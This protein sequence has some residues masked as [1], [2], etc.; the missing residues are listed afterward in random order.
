MTVDPRLLYL[1]LLTRLAVKDDSIET[2][3][4]MI[5]LWDSMTDEQQADIIAALREAGEE[6]D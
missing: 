5:A 4:R 3:S 1:A 6:N 2:S